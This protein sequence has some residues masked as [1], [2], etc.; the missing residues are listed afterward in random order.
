[1]SASQPPVLPP[2][3]TA[4]DN[5]SS[6]SKSIHVEREFEVSPT[7][8]YSIFVDSELHSA[9][10][11]GDCHVSEKAGASFDACDGWIQGTVVESQH[12]KKLVQKWRGKNWPAGHFST[13][14]LTFESLAPE[15][16][17]W[18]EKSMLT[19]Q[20]DNFPPGE[21]EKIKEGWD[22][23]Y[24]KPIA[25]WAAGRAYAKKKM[26]EEGG[27][28]HLEIPVLDFER[29]KGFYGDVFGWTFQDAMPGYVLF[30]TRAQRHGLS[31]GLYL[32][33]PQDADA[34]APD[35]SPSKRRRSSRSP[36]KG[37][38]AEEKPASAMPPCKIG[39]NNGMNAHIGVKEI[40]DALSSIEKHGGK[41]VLPKTLITEQVGWFAK[42]TDTE[43]NL[44][45]L[46]QSAKKPENH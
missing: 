18:K 38:E 32:A 44:F 17:S 13:L 20:Q 31:G 39:E 24:W 14:T 45:F 30:F 23:H 25:G 26:Y 29:A 12:G 22:T 27:I 34:T 21:A 7:L 16:Q 3:M 43:G 35:E 11:G 41:T 46:Y 42:F 19:L 9:I 15:S 10:V 1:M 6:E 4:S 28:C 40:D 36:R 2:T 37:D 33:N 5:S 8:L